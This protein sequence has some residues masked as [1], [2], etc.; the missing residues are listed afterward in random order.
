MNLVAFVRRLSKSKRW[1]MPAD[2]MMMA[3]HFL[4]ASF[5]DGKKNNMKASFLC[6]IILECS[7]KVLKMSFMLSADL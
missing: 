4:R 2:G 3:F 6:N 7:F 5:Y 1:Y